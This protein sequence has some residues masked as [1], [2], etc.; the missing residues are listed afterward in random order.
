MGAP[1]QLPREGD[2]MTQVAILLWRAF[3]CRPALIA[4]LLSICIDAPSAIAEPPLAE[5]EIRAAL[6]QWT[7][8][9]NAG[10]ADKV[11]SLFA[12]DLVADVRGAAERDFGV[13]CRL[14]RKALA[15]PD[16]TY[17]YAFSLKEVLV[18]RDMAVARLTWTTTTRVK[19]TDVATT[20]Q[21]E[22][23]DVFGR[24]TDGKWVILRYMAYERP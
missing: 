19:A 3:V 23:L 1:V 13:Q 9:F 24:G 20:T 12:G 10:H 4:V 8:D 21:D 2:F 22:G 15:D 5:T 11:C 18:G 6:E 14:L 7:S 17:T 16:R